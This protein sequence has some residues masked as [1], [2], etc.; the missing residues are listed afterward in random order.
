ME[1]IWQ[2]SIHGHISNDEAFDDGRE[3]D[4]VELDFEFRDIIIFLNSVPLNPQVN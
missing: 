4:V 3:E 1:F 2:Q